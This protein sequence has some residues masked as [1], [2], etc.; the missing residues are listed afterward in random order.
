MTQKNHNMQNSC[1]PLEEL[2]IP[3]KA[4]G[5]VRHVAALSQGWA[6]Q[7]CFL[8]YKPPPI[9]GPDGSFPIGSKESWLQRMEFLTLDLIWLLELKQY[10][11][12]SQIIYGEKTFDVVMTFLRDAHPFYAQN[13]FPEDAEMWKRFQKVHHLVFLVIVRLSTW[14]E[15]EVLRIVHFYENT[16]PEMYRKLSVLSDKDDTIHEYVDLKSKLDIM[17][18]EWLKVFRL[19]IATCI[20]EI[21]MNVDTLT[22]AI[23]KKNVDDYVGILT[24]CLSEKVF[25]TDYHSAYPVDQD[26]DTLS[27]LCPEMDFMKCDFLLEAVLSNFDVPNKYDK[28]NILRRARDR[29]PNTLQG[30]NIMNGDATASVVRKV[31]GVELDSLIT[32]VKDILPHLGDGFVEV[33]ERMI[34]NAVLEGTLAQELQNIDPALPK[35]PPDP[36]TEEAANCIQRLNIFDND[37]F[38]IM[39]QDEIDTSKIHRGKRKSQYKNLNQLI[40]DKTHRSEFREMY[41]KFGLVDTEGSMY[42]DEYDDTYDHLDVSVG[43]EGDFER[44]P[45]VVPRILQTNEES[46]S[47]EQS[48]REG[49]V[50]PSKPPPRDEFVQN[51]E[52]LRAKAEQRRQQHMQSRGRGWRSGPH[53]PKQR[54]VVGR[55]KGQGQD[56]QVVINRDHKNV[57]KGARGNHNRRAGAQRKRQQGMM[58][59]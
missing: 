5:V 8:H 27:Q 44:R 53:P 9:P 26:L 32:E 39:T 1:V 21:S 23:V 7:R 13:A 24:E 55:P 31:K 46:S 33:I 10:R 45:I 30:S 16:I 20:N 40:D 36:E 51:P 50:E 49:P 34:V 58:P 4:N 42:D 3:L 56:K 18:P 29:I 52:E 57:N 22:E 38:D 15:S 59:F 35:I 54:D 17:R 14:R 25:I 37:P 6:E 48:D 28:L 2:K 41:T 12:W 11:F 43:E 47:E 19:C